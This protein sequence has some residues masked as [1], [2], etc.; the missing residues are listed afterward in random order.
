MYGITRI[1]YKEGLIRQK[2][3]RPFNPTGYY[4]QFRVLFFIWLDF[5]GPYKTYQQAE[6][7]LKEIKETK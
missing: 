2:D 6:K 3:G 5:K 1:K 7:Y 4:I